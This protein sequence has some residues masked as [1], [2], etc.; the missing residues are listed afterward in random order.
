[1]YVCLPVCIHLCCSMEKKGCVALNLSKIEDMQTRLQ[2]N[3]EAIGMLNQQVSARPH[4]RTQTHT[5]TRTH[6]VLT[7]LLPDRYKHTP[8]HRPTCCWAHTEEEA[9]MRPTSNTQA[10]LHRGAR[11]HPFPLPTIK[12]KN[13][14]RGGVRDVGGWCGEVGCVCVRGGDKSY[15]EKA[16]T[17]LSTGKWFPFHETER[18]MYI[19]TAVLI[20]PWQH[21]EMARCDKTMWGK[22]HRGI[23]LGNADIFYCVELHKSQQITKEETNQKYSSAPSVL[24]NSRA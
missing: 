17:F 3:L 16:V 13:R 4:A 18:E 14:Q 9:F 1:M 11:R 10:H 15:R 20:S 24:Q 2:S 21:R 5:R 19:N 22:K 12:V 8:T 7:V 23:F 6:R